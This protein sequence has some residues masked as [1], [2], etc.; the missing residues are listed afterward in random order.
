MTG[1]SAE[2]R[3]WWDL[4]RW[5]AIFAYI[6]ERKKV[7]KL[8]AMD[9][10]NG[11]KCP[12]CDGTHR[13]F[14]RWPVCPERMLQEPLVQ[15]LIGLHNARS[16]CPLTNWPDGWLAFVPAA[17]IAAHNESLRVGRERREEEQSAW[18]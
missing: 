3:E 4:N 8:T 5:G 10:P 9:T 11:K 14:R 6:F 18:A 17:L 15:M 13:A 2:D 1:G 16:L 12:G 7:H